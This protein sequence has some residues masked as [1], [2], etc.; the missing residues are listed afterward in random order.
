MTF[1]GYIGVTRREGE[2][3]WFIGSHALLGAYVAVSQAGADLSSTI[4]QAIADNVVTATEQVAVD[5]SASKLDSATEQLR[6][7]I[8]AA[9]GRPLRVIGG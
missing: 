9:G 4:A 3:M 1:P 5:R 8:A 6:E 2:A 7:T